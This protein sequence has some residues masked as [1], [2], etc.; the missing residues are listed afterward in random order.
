MSVST[1]TPGERDTPV[2]RQDSLQRQG[3][4][5]SQGVAEPGLAADG[6][7]DRP[8]NGPRSGNWGGFL[9]TYRPPAGVYDEM[10]D[11]AGELRAPWRKLIPALDRLGPE[12]LVRQ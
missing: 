2:E 6:P 8:P 3:S 9:P 7:S 10:V 1:E 5:Q 4:L 11:A 12:G